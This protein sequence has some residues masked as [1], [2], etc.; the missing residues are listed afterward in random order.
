MG[1]EWRGDN[2]TNVAKKYSLD[3]D[4]NNNIKIK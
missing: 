4:K 3:S 2:G 1:A